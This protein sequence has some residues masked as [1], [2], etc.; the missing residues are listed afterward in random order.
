MSTSEDTTWEEVSDN[1]LYMMTPEQ[2]IDQLSNQSQS[3]SQYSLAPQSPSPY[4]Q[5]PY[6]LQTIIPDCTPYIAALVTANGNIHL[7]CEQL[8]ITTAQFLLA[9]ASD[10]N[11]EM[12]LQRQLRTYSSILAFQM[13][14][15]SM[16]VLQ[17]KLHELE[18]RDAAKNFTTILNSIEVLTR[19]HRDV[20]NVNVFEAAMRNVPAHIRDALQV[21]AAVKSQQAETSLGSNDYNDDGSSDD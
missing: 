3:S 13:V 6:N 17:Q 21:L 12:I 5:P 20:T 19:N 18:P 16:F 15:E 8:G 7:A 9:V 11:S 2:L 10:P 4:S 1:P 14:G